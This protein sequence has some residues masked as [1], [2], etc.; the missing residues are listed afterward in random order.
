MLDSIFFGNWCEKLV[1]GTVQNKRVH[2]FG[3][4]Y[5]ETI[6][7]F[8]FGGIYANQFYTFPSFKHILFMFLKKSFGSDLLQNFQ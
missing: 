7:G 4:A 1:E 5:I 8:V 6:N 3:I 2:F